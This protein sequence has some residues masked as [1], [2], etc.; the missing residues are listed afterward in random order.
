[1]ESVNDNKK[2]GLLAATR[3]FS[4]P[5]VC[6]EHVSKSKWPNG[7]QCPRCESKKLS[8]IKTRM[9]WTCL[10]CRKQFS[11]K[12]GTIFEDSAIGLNKWLPAM[13][14]VVNCKN[15]ISSYE[16]ARDLEVTQRT[17][18]FML[19]RIRH[20]MHTGSIN[21][22]TGVIEADETFVGGAARFMHHDKKL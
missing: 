7:P 8:F 21:K 4:D 20:A 14:L 15:G 10:D 13:W 19:Q 6:L 2:Q 16:L 18:W 1:M 11:V 12:V 17:G 9:L 22:M 5:M 3:Y